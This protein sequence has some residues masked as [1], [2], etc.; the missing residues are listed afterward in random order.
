MYLEEFSKMSTNGRK[1]CFWA[2]LIIL[3]LHDFVVGPPGLVA[4]AI[5][6]PGPQAVAFGVRL[7]AL[8]KLLL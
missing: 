7:R 3:V 6:S 1:S 5:L 8:M 2:W 4:A